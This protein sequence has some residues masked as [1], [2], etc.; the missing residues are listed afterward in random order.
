MKKMLL[1]VVAIGLITG[2]CV[3]TG[4]E[5]VNIIHPKDGSLVFQS[6]MVDG[7]SSAK[8]GMNVNVLVWPIEVHGPWWVQ[9][10][11]TKPDGSWESNANFGG[12]GSIDNGKTFKIIAILTDQELR[13]GSTFTDLPP[14]N[15]TSEEIGVTRR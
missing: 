14:H 9:S 6:S 1:L 12:V 11:K 7:N 4:N 3:G 2:L 8:S 5:F 15:A 13:V 10:T